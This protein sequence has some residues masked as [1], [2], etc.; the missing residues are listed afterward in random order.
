MQARGDDIEIISAGADGILVTGPIAV[1]VTAW[2]RGGPSS[3]PIL[4]TTVGGWR[5][6]AGGSP[7][8]PGNQA[9]RSGHSIIC[10]LGVISALGNGLPFAQAIESSYS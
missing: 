8:G 7:K 10:T 1:R 9:T 6:H 5:V 4:P 3:S 2:T